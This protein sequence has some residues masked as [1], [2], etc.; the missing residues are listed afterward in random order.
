MLPILRR[1]TFYFSLA[2]AILFLLIHF[3]NPLRHYTHGRQTPIEKLLH[4]GLFGRKF[5]WRDV[6]VRHAVV[7]LTEL[8][9]GPLQHIPQI[10]ARFEEETEKQRRKREARLAAVRE[11]FVHSWE[12]YK[13]HAWPQDE[14]GP[15]SGAV[16]NTFGGWG[17]TLVDSLDTLWIMG[18]STEFE[19]AVLALRRTD[20]TSSSQPQINVFETA[21][22]YLGGLL[23][24][25]DLSEHR[26]PLLLS[27]A[28]EVGDM[29][30]VAFDTPNH[31][32]VTRWDWKNG[33][34]GGP[35]EA[36]R[37]SLLAEVGSFSLEFTRLSQVTG[38]ARW[39]DA[40]ARIAGLLAD[41]Q[42][43]THIPGLFP[44]MLDT[45]HADFTRDNTFTW[46]GMADSVYEYMPKMHLLLGGRAPHYRSIWSTALA[47][48]KE[49]LFFYPMNPSNASILLSGTLKRNSATRRKLIP[50]AEHL[51]CFAGGAVALAAKIFSTPEDLTTARELLD[52]CLWAYES[53]PTGIMPEIF[54]ASPCSPN[55]RQNCTWNAGQ[56]YSAINGDSHEE[57]QNLISQRNLPPGFVEIPDPRYLLRPET[58]ESIFVLYRITGEESLRDKAWEIFQ[59]IDKAA[60]TDIAYAGIAD[61]TQQKMKRVDSMES[62]WMGETL[63][64][65]YLVF[66]EP[67]V[68]SLD[69]W[70]L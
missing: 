27:K 55:P 11:A 39:Y 58:I 20:F 65:F 26:Y 64:Y 57:A 61:V 70:V 51:S 68:V 63:K 34:L 60:R 16:Y 48:A 54:H 19:R 44:T 36:A 62:F 45:Q 6:S 3:V 41:A 56:W 9:T 12:G 28:I 42:N 14:V 52:G 7:N 47:A 38:D 15:L 69:D 46:G 32:P 33:A 24:A 31:L 21:I 29:L 49:H 66:S 53:T 1:W 59:S 4:P 25:Y 17:A 22:R 8:P 10:Q 35:Q 13:K 37:F 2:A 67:E 5:R 30:L 40:A 18:M 50:Q 43:R 23:S